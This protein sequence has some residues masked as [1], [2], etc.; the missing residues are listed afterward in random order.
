M[1]SIYGNSFKNL[2]QR[3]YVDQSH[4]CAEIGKCFDSEKSSLAFARISGTQTCRAPKNITIT[5]LSSTA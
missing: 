4:V 5:L 2:A 3:S 1:I